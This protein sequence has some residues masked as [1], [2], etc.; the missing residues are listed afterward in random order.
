[1]KAVIKEPMES[2]IEPYRADF[3]RRL[4]EPNRGNGYYGRH[5]LTGLGD[6]ELTI[7]T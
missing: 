4:S 6:I 1:M 5:L 7:N 3:G 2:N